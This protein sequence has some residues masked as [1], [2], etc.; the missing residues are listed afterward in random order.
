MELRWCG[1]VSEHS[2][3]AL[4]WCGAVSEHSASALHW[5]GAVSDCS[6]ME[7]HWC[8]AVSD[9]KYRCRAT[10]SAIGGIGVQTFNPPRSGC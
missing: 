9:G 1:A 5:C 7:L 4:H 6:A 3:S 8:G 2:A 10:V